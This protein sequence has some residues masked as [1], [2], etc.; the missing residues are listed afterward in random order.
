MKPLARQTIV[1]ALKAGEVRGLNGP[2]VTMVFTDTRR[3]TPG[4]LFVALCGDN[5]DGHD[6]LASALEA[7]ACGVVISKPQSLPSNLDAETFVV[8][9]NDTREGGIFAK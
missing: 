8:V 6:H 5:F 7:G 4:G 2:D 3:P 1:T 9:V